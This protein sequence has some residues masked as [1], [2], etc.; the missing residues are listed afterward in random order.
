MYIVSFISSEIKIQNHCGKN[1]EKKNYTIQTAELS[2][3]SR[4][5]LKEDPQTKL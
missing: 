2:Q 1:F 5:E 3:I 4:K